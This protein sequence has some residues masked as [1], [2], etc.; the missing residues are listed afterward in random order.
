M[1]VVVAFRQGRRHPRVVSLLVWFASTAAL[2]VLVSAPAQLARSENVDSG[3]IV[4]GILGGL[5]SLLPLGASLGLH[6]WL[7]IVGL[8]L[9][10]AVMMR[11]TASNRQ[12]ATMAA[13][14]AASLTLVPPMGGL[15]AFLGLNWVPWRTLTLPAMA[16]A[17]GVV[18]LASAAFVVGLRMRDARRSSSDAPHRPASRAAAL[19]ALTLTA[20][21]VASLPLVERALVASAL[22]AQLAVARDALV[23]EQLTAGESE[24]DVHPAP[25][26]L[27]PSDTR[28]FEFRE[29]QNKDWFSA[30]YR[31]WFEVPATTTFV[32]ETTQPLGY[33]VDDDRVIMPGVTPCSEKG[34]A[35]D[36]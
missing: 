31:S 2:L 32:Y 30:G 11:P 35:D 1:L 12:V 16:F 13:I 22:R 19:A 3:S 5:Y 18:L 36:G 27:Y 21:V 7:L 8:A 10:L 4:V 26:L 14:G 24:I 33:C 6:G 20:S 29:V 25:L 23:V 17:W 15:V 28:D 34:A 9:A